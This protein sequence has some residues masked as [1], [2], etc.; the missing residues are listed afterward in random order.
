MSIFKKRTHKN[1]RK[2]L[3]Y[4]DDRGV[5]SPF[6]YHLE[7]SY[8]FTIHFK[9]GHIET[10]KSAE[11]CDLNDYDYDKRT[12][13]TFGTILIGDVNGDYRTVSFRISDVDWVDTSVHS[14][15]VPHTL[16]DSL[17]A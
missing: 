12:P 2:Q 5:L 17:F 1:T 9:D 16:R 6:P 7:K 15:K 10:Y 14:W 4:V 3:E 13:K 11:F 8:D